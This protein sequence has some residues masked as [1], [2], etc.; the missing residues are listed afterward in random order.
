[1]SVPCTVVDSFSPW[2]A[3][4]VELGDLVKSLSD[5][6]VDGRSHH[7]DVVKIP[8]ERQQGVTAGY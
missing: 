2:I 7:L 1:L 3:Q 5:G 8:D 4:T 6:V